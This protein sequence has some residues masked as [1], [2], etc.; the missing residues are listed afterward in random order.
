MQEEKGA[1]EDEMVVWYHRLDGHEPEQTP[2]VGDLQ[3]GGHSLATEQQMIE[4]KVIFF[5]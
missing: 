3:G 2:G 5:P 1:S 4:R